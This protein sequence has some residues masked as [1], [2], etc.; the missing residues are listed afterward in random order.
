MALSRVISDQAW[1]LCFDE[2]HVTY[3]AD[4]MI[5]SRLFKALFDQ[6]VVVA[7]SNRPPE[8]LYKAGLQR[9]TFLPFIDLLH[10]KL[11]VLE[12]DAG[13]DYRLDRLKTMDVYLT[14]ADSDAENKL[15]ED[16]L[17]LIH[18]QPP[19]WQDRAGAELG[20]QLGCTDETNG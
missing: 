7:T 1:L 6:G 11:D 3:I 15:D 16:F 13:V 17:S 14:P 18:R 5:L 2:F 19:R 9:D 20:G 10:D 4:A 8:D 12:I